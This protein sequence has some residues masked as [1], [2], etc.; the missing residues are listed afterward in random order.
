MT[1]PFS[2]KENVSPRWDVR[3][4]V[5]FV[6]V[7]LLLASAGHAQENSKA[8]TTTFSGLIDLNFAWNQNRPTN[9]Q[10][11]YPGAGTSAKRANE[12]SLNLAQVQWTRPVSAQQPVGFT[13]GLIAGEGA[14]VV[15]GGE[16]EG[17]GKFRHVY[18]ASVA[19]RLPGGIV[20]EGGIYP[21]HI[22]LEGFYSKDN[23]NYTR[24]IMG[25]SSPYYQAGIKASCAFDAHW[26]GRVDLLNGWQLIDDNND[27]KAIGSQIAYNSDA[28]TASLNT[29]LGPEL[30]DDDDSLR[31]FVDVVVLYKVT[32][33]L[34]LGGTADFGAQEIPNTDDVRWN[35]E[36][37]YLRY[38]VNGRNA[39]A[40]RLERFSDP[41]NGI[42][43]TAQRL[44][45]ATLTY[46]LRPRDNVI[47]KLEGRYD[48]SDADVFSKRDTTTVDHQLLALAGV[49]VTF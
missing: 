41:D 21:S 19:Y 35:G 17:V 34:Q 48:K 42:T 44:R 11:F 9:H 39:I 30:A 37:L 43:G 40:A 28:L 4:P 5:F 22:G 2:E 33:R 18:Q 29:F 3:L 15:H 26:S 14:D 10:N 36:A 25:E 8:S 1:F 12:F 16:P 45:E 23:W 7:F 46:E 13:V 47:L 20:L 31:K 27:G 6:L 49:V 32:P 38:A 24:S